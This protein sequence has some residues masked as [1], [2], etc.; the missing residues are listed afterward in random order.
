[1]K[2]T[3]TE[4]KLISAEKISKLNVSK[5]VRTQEIKTIN[6]SHMIWMVKIVFT[7]ISS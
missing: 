4:E 7:Q 1:M 6:I 5:R 3:I 2:R